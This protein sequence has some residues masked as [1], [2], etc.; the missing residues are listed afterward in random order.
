MQRLI[1]VAS[2]LIFL[3]SSFAP[4]PTRVN[5]KDFATMMSNLKS[6]AGRFRQRSTTR[7][8]AAQSD[9]PARKRT[10]RI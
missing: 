1:V 6:D 10:Q 5:D 8:R 3:G 9:I 2:L 7:S 4:A